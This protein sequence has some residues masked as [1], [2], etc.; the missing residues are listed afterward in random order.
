MQARKFD[1]AAAYLKRWLPELAALPPQLL[2]EPWRDPEA[3]TARGY[4]SPM[5]DLPASRLSAL[6][7]WQALQGNNT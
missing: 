5:V 6:S 2:H 4:P 1:P 7:A 3:L